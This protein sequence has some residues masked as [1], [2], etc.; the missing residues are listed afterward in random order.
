MDPDQCK[1]SQKVCFT[2]PEPFMQLFKP[3]A[4]TKVGFLDLILMCSIKPHLLHKEEV[5]A[6]YDKLDKYPTRGFAGNYFFL[7]RLNY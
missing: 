4:K 2:Q 3:L 6:W 1:S 7:T 5:E